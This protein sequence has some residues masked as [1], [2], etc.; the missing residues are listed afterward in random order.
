MVAKKGN[1]KFSS[2][3]LEDEARVAVAATFEKFVAQLANT[4]TAVHVWLAVPL[5]KIAKGQKAFQL[6]VLGQVAQAADDCGVDGKEPT[7]ASS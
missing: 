1:K 3:V 5:D 7:Q 6:F 2:P 4:K